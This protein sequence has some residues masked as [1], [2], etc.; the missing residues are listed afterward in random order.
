MNDVIHLA[1]G[2]NA[3]MPQ[4]RA[5]VTVHVPVAADLSALLLDANGRLRG[6]EDFVFY[7]QPN[8][9]GVTCVPPSGGQPWKVQV[10]L[11]Q[12]P[13]DIDK[14]RLVTSLDEAGRTF[15][16]IGGAPIATVSTADGTPVAESELTGL[17][18]ESIV[19]AL[20]FYRRNGEWKVRSVGQGYAGGLADLIRDHGGAVDDE[21]SSGSA[22]PAAAAAPVAAPAAQPAPAAQTPPPAQPAQP[23]PPAQPA[24]AAPAAPPLPPQPSY[25]QQ[26]AYGQQQPAYGQQQNVNQPPPPPA[27]PQDP[28]L[29]RG[30]PVNLSKGQR[31]NLK[32]EDGQRLTYIR[33]GLGWD[34]IK[35][36]GLFGRRDAEVDLDASAILLAGTEPVDIAFYN[37]LASQDGSIQ[38][39]GDN[40]TGAGDGD[41]ESIVVDL[42][43]VPTHVT[44]IMFVVSSYEGQTFTMIQNAFCRLVD[45]AGGGAELARY[46]LTGGAPQTGMVMARVYRDGNDWKLEAIGEPIAARTPH[47]SLPQLARFVR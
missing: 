33:M 27:P 45:E 30:R 32:K 15:G 26:P 7:N 21:G 29:T 41:D 10:D 9:P 37:H 36:S 12:V 1:K 11:D 6:D 16:S 5:T 20:E 47:D 35:K 23:T 19:V 31:V 40:R 34:P 8:G 3:P 42:T 25:D 13:Q 22:T 28:G 17:S 43:R 46:T 2:Q 4:H 14:V 39:T 44:S 24:P 38:H 18:T